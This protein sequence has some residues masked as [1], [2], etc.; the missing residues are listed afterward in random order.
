MYVCAASDRIGSDRIWGE[1]VLV[2]EIS[3]LGCISRA[4]IGRLSCLV[5]DK[6]SYNYSLI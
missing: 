6:I 1:R 2:S 5:H 3:E 4:E